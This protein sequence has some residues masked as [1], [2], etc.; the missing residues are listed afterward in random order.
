MELVQKD[1]NREITRCVL[2]YNLD[3]VISVGYRTNSD[4]VIQFRRWATFVLREFLKK[5]YI[6]DKKRMTN[7]AFFDEY[8]YDLLLSESRE[9]NLDIL[10]DAGKILHEIACDKVLT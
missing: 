4:R 5:G 9:I 2:Y 10:N 6:I 1:G 3:V 7:G 8:Y